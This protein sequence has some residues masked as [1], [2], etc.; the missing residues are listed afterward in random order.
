MPVISPESVVGLI[1][2]HQIFEC[3]TGALGLDD[4]L[5]AQG[6][7]SMAMMQLMLHLEKDFGVRI[8][9]AEMT[10][11]HFATVR[12]LADWLS[13]PNRATA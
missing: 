4:D 9:P 10:R 3:D 6:L 1:H 11:N 7:D 13:H 8:A 2:E 12:V 5:F